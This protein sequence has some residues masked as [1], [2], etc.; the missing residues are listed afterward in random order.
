M[1]KVKPITVDEIV[2]MLA[3]RDAGDTFVS[4]GRQTGRCNTRIRDRLVPIMIARD[5]ASC[6]GQDFDVAAFLAIK[7][8]EPVVDVVPTKAL[9]PMW[10]AERADEGSRLCGLGH[11]SAFIARALNRMPGLSVSIEDVNRRSAQ[12]NRPSPARPKM[13]PAEARA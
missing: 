3:L 4:I 1:S 7:A 12:W 5:A 11:T 10:T 8:T 6:A 2:R 9:D 13:L